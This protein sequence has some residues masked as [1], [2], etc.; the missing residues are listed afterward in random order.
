MIYYITKRIILF[1][2]I[3]WAV[4]LN[5]RLILQLPGYSLKMSSHSRDSDLIDLGY[6]FDIKVFKS[7][8]LILV[9]S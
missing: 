8:Q 6:R 5:F 9:Y 3:S 1:R 2:V 4:V 7:S